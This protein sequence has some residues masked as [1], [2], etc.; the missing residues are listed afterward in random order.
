MQKKIHEVDFQRPEKEDFP[1]LGVF[2]PP[3]EPVFLRKV[4]YRFFNLTRCK[5]LVPSNITPLCVRCEEIFPNSC[6]YTVVAPHTICNSCSQPSLSQGYQPYYIFW[7]YSCT[8]GCRTYP[9][10]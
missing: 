9:P 8:A 1:V 3:L 2:K 4:A 7:R 10:S 5:I 6:C